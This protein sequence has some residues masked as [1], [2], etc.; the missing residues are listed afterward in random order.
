MS[1]SLRRACAALALVA[2]CAHPDRMA[3]A[4]SSDATARV[5]LVQRGRHV[6]LRA[7]VNGHLGQFVL[8]TGAAVTVLDDGFAARC[9]LA[10]P[11]MGIEGSRAGQM[12]TSL[13]RAGCVALGGAAVR[14]VE[15]AVLDLQ[16]LE[17]ALGGKPDGLLG[18][19]ALSRYR[20]TIDPIREELVLEHPDRAPAPMP[21]VPLL[22]GSAAGVPVVTARVGGIAGPFVLDSGNGFALEIDQDVARRTGVRTTHRAVAAGVGGRFAVSTVALERFEL[23]GHVWHG[24]EAALWDSP[25]P[26]AT[27]GMIGWPLL[28]Q[29][30]CT[31]EPTRGRVWLVPAGGPAVNGAAGGP[32]P[33]N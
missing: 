20:V 9:G 3:F 4:G 25:T 26:D 32:P 27:A 30:V 12:R 18:W 2:T 14:E 24:V 13:A 17:R 8:D 1:L 7:S 15:V 19:N 16:P 10:A 21:G 28:S 31:F 33:G 22:L 6:W 23:A 11:F 29:F 5:P